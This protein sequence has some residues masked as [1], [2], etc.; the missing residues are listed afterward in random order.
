MPRKMSCHQPQEGGT[1][2]TL[3]VLHAGT[4]EGWAGPHVQATK[5]YKLLVNGGV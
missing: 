3:F 4:L 2:V 1:A 5:F